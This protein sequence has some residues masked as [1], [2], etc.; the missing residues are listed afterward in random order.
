MLHA[1]SNN[2]KQYSELRL[3]NYTKEIMNICQITQDRWFCYSNLTGQQDKHDMVEKV[4]WL[5]FHDNY[6]KKPIK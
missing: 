1:Y 6:L 3:S 2:Y 5:L 4:K